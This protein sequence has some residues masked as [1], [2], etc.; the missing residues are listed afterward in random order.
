MTLVSCPA[1]GGCSV[2][3]CLLFLLI[4]LLLLP[5]VGNCRERTKVFLDFFDSDHEE[6]RGMGALCW[7][8]AGLR[9]QNRVLGVWQQ[10]FV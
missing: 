9:L 7:P 5:T 8:Q 10:V 4:S 6:I 1:P 2:N 3:I